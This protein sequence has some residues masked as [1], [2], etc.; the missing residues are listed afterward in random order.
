MSSQPLPPEIADAIRR[1]DAAVADWPE[2]LLADWKKVRGYCRSKHSES[3][4]VLPA[5]SLVAQ[6]IAQSRHHAQAALDAM[7]GVFGPRR[8]EVLRREEGLPDTTKHRKLPDDGK[9]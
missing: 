4:R 9:P 5:A 3:Q 7:S 2:E 1:V 8:E 6:E